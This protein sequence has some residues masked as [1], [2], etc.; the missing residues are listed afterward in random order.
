MEKDNSNTWL[1]S[2]GNEQI[3]SYT[4]S[5]DVMVVER[6]R[7]ISLFGNLFLYNFPSPVNLNILDIGCGDGIVTECLLNKYPQNNFS[8]MD[9][10]AVMLL[11]AK[12]RLKDKPVEF[13][14][15]SF[16]E[17]IE[18]KP[19]NNKYNFVFS[20]MATHHLTF[21]DKGALYSKIKEELC[22]NGLFLNFDVVLPTSE[23]SEK[24]QFQ[25]WVDWMNETLQKNNLDTELSKFDDLP[26]IYKAKE[27]NKPS[28]LF[29]QLDLLT[30]AGYKDV[31]CFFKYSIF[32]LFGGK[33]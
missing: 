1:N 22:K 11:K 32:A 16:E 4:K 3:E 33:K 2:K 24:I 17:Y 8:L 6:N 7:V 27:E 10:S 20:S 12:E 14:E 18:K 15:M 25:M 5:A 21:N 19:E 29:D 28:D 26:N 13:I 9:G 30:K 31:D 23:I